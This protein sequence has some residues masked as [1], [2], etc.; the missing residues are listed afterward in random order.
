MFGM[1]NDW[2]MDTRAIPLE[3]TQGFQFYRHH[4]DNT[5]I[6]DMKGSSALRLFGSYNEFSPTM[7]LG[8]VERYY[9]RLVTMD[10][11]FKNRLFNA[12]TMPFLDH[13]NFQRLRYPK[14]LSYTL[15]SEH[16]M[17]GLD[18]VLTNR[19]TGAVGTDITRNNAFCL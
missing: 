4:Q 10:C 3:N 9:Q 1:N 16:F 19:E 18:F 8:D 12:V 11:V 7:V 17:R 6:L 13:T 15:I 14:Q 5:P 2:L